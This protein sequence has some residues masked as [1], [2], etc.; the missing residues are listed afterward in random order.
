MGRPK[1]LL[2]WE[3]ESFLA[4][5][6]HALREGGCAEV[7]V[8]TGPEEDEETARVAEAARRAGARVAVNPR[9]QAEQIDSL[10]VGLAALP[11]RAEAAVVTPADVPG[12][13]PGTVR[14]LIGAFR[15]GGRP[16][17]LPVHGGSHGHPGLFGRAV[18][19]EL[20]ADPLPEG[21]HTVIRAHAAEIEEV[22]VENPGVLHDVDTPDDYRRLVD[23]DGGA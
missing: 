18:W 5:V 4:R 13:D 9:A 19:G 1:P 6:V 3:G 15:R 17:V 7:V 8:V 16:I 23:G 12:I 21:A 11:P 10:R 20:L 14:A 22:P 2:R